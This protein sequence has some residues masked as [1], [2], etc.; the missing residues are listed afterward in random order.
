MWLLNALTVW[1]KSYAVGTDE[2]SRYYS[3]YFNDEEFVTLTSFSG[4]S[5][6]AL[7]VFEY[8]ASVGWLIVIYVFLFLGARRKE[9]KSI[10]EFFSQVSPPCVAAMLAMVIFDIKS[11]ATEFEY[12]TSE[13]LRAFPIPIVFP[14][15]PSSIFRWLLRLSSCTEV[16]SLF[17]D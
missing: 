8:V 13:W 10:F 5:A 11:F 17:R 7:V 15:S 3:L 1:L 12:S 4:D 2:T 6:A 9:L 16:V 14:P